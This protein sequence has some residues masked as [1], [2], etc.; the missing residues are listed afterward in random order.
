[1]LIPERHICDFCGTDKFVR[2]NIKLPVHTNCDWTEGKACDDRIDFETYDICHECLAKA[3]NI[4][5][6]FQGS[7]PRI[8]EG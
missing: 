4:H 7:H 6:D 2:V 3:T 8:K 1:M 5:C